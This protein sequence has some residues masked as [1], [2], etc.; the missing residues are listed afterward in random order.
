MESGFQ[1]N[2]GSLFLVLTPPLSLN[3]EIQG[4]ARLLGEPLGLR[5]KE[6]V[7]FEMEWPG[8]EP[9]I[10]E[11]QKRTLYPLL[12]APPAFETLDRVLEFLYF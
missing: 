12:H 10:L 7:F 5:G 1:Y 6:V 3:S 2:H 9:Q 11:L 4:C 8:L